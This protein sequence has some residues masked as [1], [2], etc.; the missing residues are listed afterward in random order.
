MRPLM[1][2]AEKVF[3]FNFSSPGQL[4]VRVMKANCQMNSIKSLKKNP[5]YRW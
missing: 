5:F 1:L 4:G 2:K 3:V